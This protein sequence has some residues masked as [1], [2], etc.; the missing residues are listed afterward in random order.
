MLCGFDVDGTLADSKSVYYTTVREYA[1]KNKLP[2]PSLHYMDMAF[3]SPT[4]PNFKGWGPA[5]KLKKHLDDISEIIDQKLCVDP[6]AMPIFPGV[7]N[8]LARLKD[9]GILL[10]I[11]TSRE[12][13]PV[14]NVLDAHNLIQFFPTIYSGKDVSEGKC[15]DKPH[16]DLLKSALIELNIASEKA[17]MI[18]DTWMDIKMAKNANVFAVGVTWGYHPEHILHEYKADKIVYNPQQINEIIQ[19]HRRKH[20]G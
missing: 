8:L 12:L 1:E 14:L 18:G 9:E 3:G 10:T 11:I 13:E 17:V 19:I 5:K 2:L 15:R 6:L 7:F 20:G 16:P 4:P